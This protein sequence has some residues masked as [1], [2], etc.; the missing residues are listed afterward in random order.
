MLGPR[1]PLL[2]LSQVDLLQQVLLQQLPLMWHLP[3]LLLLR[4]GPPHPCGHKAAGGFPCP[5]AWSAVTPQSMLMVMMLTWQRSSCWLC[6]TP[7]Q[8]IMLLLLLMMMVMMLTWQRSSCWLCLTPHQ[9]IML[10][11]LLLLMLM[12]MML[13]WQRSSCWR[14]LRRVT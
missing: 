12:V 2:C 11:L 9:R 13:T 8:R 10:L 4:A 7:R 5:A 14:C 1:H 3:A 6:L